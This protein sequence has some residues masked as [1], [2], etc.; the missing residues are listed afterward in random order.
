MRK[1]MF[2]GAAALITIVATDPAFCLQVAPPAGEAT[3]PDQTD[4]NTPPAPPVDDPSQPSPPITEPL[5]PEMPPV[6]GEGQQ[7]PPTNPTAPVQ[8][9]EPM[10]PVPTVVN[11]DVPAGPMATPP[12]PGNERAVSGG[13]TKS[14]MTPQPS[15]KEYPLCSR[16]IQ[17]SCRNPGEGLTKSS[18]KPR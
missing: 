15:T 18:R 2:L 11:R 7:N 17:D 16:T 8:P 13:A 14:M 12:T 9:T 6:A 3:Q 10:Q 4:P 1:T 5:P